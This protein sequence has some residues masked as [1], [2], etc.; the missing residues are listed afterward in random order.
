MV[1]T[2][3]LVCCRLTEWKELLRLSLPF[4]LAFVSVRPPSFA[5]KD[6]SLSSSYSSES[7]VTAL[8]RP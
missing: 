5:L 7:G 3:K 6:Y 2:A 8:L 1:G 4:G